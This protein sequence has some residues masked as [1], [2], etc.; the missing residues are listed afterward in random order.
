VS[1]FFDSQTAQV[2]R[3]R[4]GAARIHRAD[5]YITTI[6]SKRFQSGVRHSPER[7]ENMTGRMASQAARNRGTVTT[8]AASKITMSRR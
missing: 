5:I 8:A 1:I 7:D 4:D 3:T 6:G 2:W